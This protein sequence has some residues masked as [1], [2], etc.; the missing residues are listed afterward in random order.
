MLGCETREGE[1]KR[2]GGRAAVLS[3]AAERPDLGL[4]GRRKRG[5]PWYK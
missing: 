1:G 2:G 5:G 3:R 4:V